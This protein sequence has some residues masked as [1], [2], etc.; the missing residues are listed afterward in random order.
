MR[1]VSWNCCNG[2]GSKEKIAYFKSFNADIAILPELREGNIEKLSPDCAIWITNNY[3]TTSPKGLGVL[4]FNGYD[5]LQLPRD[6][7][8]EIYIPTRVSKGDCSFNLLAVWNFYSACKQGRFKNIK[9]PKCLEYSAIDYYKDLFEDPSLIAGDW[10][11]GPTFAQEG[12]LN[13]LNILE[14]HGLRSLYH[15]HNKLS[16]KESTNHT[17]RS[18][19][20]TFHHLDHIFGSKSFV[21][22]MTSFEI[23]PFDK[24]LCSDHAPLIVDFDVNALRLAV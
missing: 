18:T 1:I 4:G 14:H 7:E 19:R 3:T 16:P 6:E 13:I 21:E 11:L 15:T 24:V 12:Y 17:Y 8:M 22:N 9:G 23:H 5:L 20:K 10:N 2:L